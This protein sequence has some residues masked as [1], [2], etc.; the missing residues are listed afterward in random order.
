MLLNQYCNAAFEDFLLTVNSSRYLHFFQDAKQIIQTKGGYSSLKSMQLSFSDLKK[1]YDTY[2]SVTASQHLLTDAWLKKTMFEEFY[3]ELEQ[4]KIERVDS[5][6]NGEKLKGVME[7][8]WQILV[9]NLHP[10]FV[11]TSKEYQE[12][13]E[14]LDGPISGLYTVTEESGILSFTVKVNSLDPV[15]QIHSTQMEDLG[16]GGTT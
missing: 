11:S 12:L 8:C 6:I 7:E 15:G 16:V 2:I 5:T 9:E 4:L 14:N 1:L 3:Q 13:K 10:A